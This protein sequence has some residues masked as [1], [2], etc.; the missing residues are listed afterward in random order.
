ME[1]S[2]DIEWAHAMAPNAKIYLVEAASTTYGNLF[3]AVQVAS[4]LVASAGGG[5]VTMSWSAGEFYYESLYDTYFTTKGVVYFAA[6]GDNYTVGY[7]A[8]S[9][10]VVAAGGTSLVRDSSGNF[11]SEAAWSSAGS[12]PSLYEYRPGYQNAVESVVGSARGAPDFAADADPNSGVWVY[13]S[14]NGGWL[15]VGGTS[16]SSPLLAGIVNKAGHFSTSTNNELTTIYGDPSTAFNDITQGS[17]G[18]NMV[19]SAVTGW[20]FCTGVGS[21]NG[22]AGK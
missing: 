10:N 18:T 16:V 7:P 11:L 22:V 5:E 19:H 6:T 9:P 4:S 2:L 15:I 8:T 17:C 21:P 13:D 12:G 3:K 14:G 20:D 1:E